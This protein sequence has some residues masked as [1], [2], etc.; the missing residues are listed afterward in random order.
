VAAAVVYS[1]LFV[2]L[3][4]ATSRALIAGLGYVVIWE[5]VLAN[6][7]GGARIL[8]VSHYGLAVAS[9]VAPGHALRP[10]VGLVTACVLGAVITAMTLAVAVRQLGS[11]SLR[12]ETA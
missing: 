6:L 3:S 2:W 10:G 8:S 7:V 12:G 1:A 4:T 5:G 9:S 11:F